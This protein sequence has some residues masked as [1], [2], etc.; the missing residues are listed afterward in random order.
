MRKMMVVGLVAL[1]LVLGGA[2]TVKAAALD[3]AKTLAI[4]AADFVKANGKEK[5][6]AE[7]GNPKGQFV[8]GDLY[9]T[10]QDTNGIALANPMNPGLVGQNHMELKDPAG[11]YFIKEF[12]EIIK[13][14][15]SGWATYQWVN[16]ATK[17]V[18]AKKAWLQKVEGTNMYT[19]CGIFE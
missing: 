14:K 19:L 6:L 3:E 18:Q 15:G 9:V 13:T 5:G 8:K 12:I 17:K 16:P 4:K 7:V 10:V 1:A 11:K 2:F